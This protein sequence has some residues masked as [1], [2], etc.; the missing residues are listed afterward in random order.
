MPEHRR[1]SSV[2]M[3]TRQ[4]QQIDES[5]ASGIDIDR[6]YARFAERKRD[7]SE[8]DDMEFVQLHDSRRLGIASL[9]A[10]AQHPRIVAFREFIEGWYLSYFTPDAARDL[11]MAGPQRRLSIHGDNLGNV[12]QYSTRAPRWF[13]HV[14]RKIASRVS[15]MTY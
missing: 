10:L 12:V 6:M 13:E 3:G 11:P 5:E 2:E 7:D 8:S 1:G 9:G 15:R 14:L 4:G